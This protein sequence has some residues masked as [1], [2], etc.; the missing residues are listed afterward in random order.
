MT[1]S[2]LAL[3]PSSRWTLAALLLLAGVFI[4]AGLLLLT[5]APVAAQAAAAPGSPLHPVFP[6]LD[7]DGKPV[8][9]SAQPIS[10]LK[11][12]GSCHDTAFI[13]T[14]T[15]HGDGGR[16]VA[17]VLPPHD[18][19]STD[20][21]MNC[22]LCHVDQPNNPAR[23]AALAAGE[24]LWA[25]T[26]TL[27]DSGIVT[28]TDSGYGYNADAFAEDGSLKPEYVTLQDPRSDNCGA[29]HGLVHL[30]NQT[31]L[32]LTIGD[33][34]L[35]RTFTTGQ[36]ISPQRITNSAANLSGRS[37]LARPW[38]VHAERVLNCVDCH[39]SI[40]NPVY[41]QP[42]AAAQ[43][44]HL[45]FDPRRPDFGEYLQRP[46]HQFASGS[47]E[48]RSCETCHDAA[49]AHDWLPYLERHTAALACESCHVPQLYAPALAYRDSTVLHIDG[50]PVDGFRG[51]DGG[52][53]TTP[54]NPVTTL[55]TG[56]QPV[57][58]QQQDADGE[59][60]LSPYNL[61]TV[62]YWAVG[63]DPA[64]PV[65]LETV[66]AIYLNDSGSNFAPE[67]LAA[68]DTDS[69]GLL[70]DA[71]LVLD[72]AAKTELITSR[73]AAAG[74][75]DAHIVGEVIPYAIHHDVIGG[76][77]AIRDCQTCHADDSRIVMTMPLGDRLPGGSLPTLVS[78]GSVGWNGTLVSDSAGLVGFATRTQT[79][80]ASLYIFGHD[81]VAL[82]DTFGMLLVLGTA[83][84]VTVH[85]SLWVVASR[86]RKQQ[87]AAAGHAA[88][89]QHAPMQ[90]EYMYTLYER[91]W[92][93]LQTF[94]IF[95]LVF[96]GIVIH[97]P[98]QFSLFS[99]AW[100][101]D[102]HNIFAALLV[103]N[104][105]LA[106]FYHL[107]SGEIRQF[108][109]R[110]YGFFDNM[111]EQALYYLRGIF[112]GD[113]HP[114]EKR[115]SQKMNPIQQ[116]TYLLLLN[117]LLPLQILSGAVMWGAQQFP[118][119]S[120]LVGGLPVLA[121]LHT[122][123]AWLLVTF[124]IV[125]VYMTTTGH[126]PLANIQAMIMGYEEIEVGGAAAPGSPAQPASEGPAEG[127]AVTPA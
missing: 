69:D 11:T 46:S 20:V 96:T 54:T 18:L 19:P 55:I 65:P 106:L 78:D 105:A 56:Y 12:C 102:V 60:S 123:V 107:T 43:P 98:E 16:T 95:G 45:L 115:Q 17:G 52:I 29:C 84:G 104:A 21:E 71:E 51:I 97:R 42:A 82:V 94:V 34:Q 10:T 58:L 108:I 67:I 35:W 50:S 76:E 93:W 113:P 13:T 48:M 83:F 79:P 122:L 59:P 32:N 117:V 5:A 116:V 91:Q 118:A 120:D 41:M 85:A 66:Q 39:F 2:R 119:V 101:V 127:S 3:T 126:T 87:A 125:H 4:S 7:A 63:T 33:E 121:P 23:L 75:A 37:D 47:A 77:W 89:S 38:D 49:V 111:V 26:A 62:W 72:T 28:R 92:H 36:V 86:R 31:P 90:R 103:I 24:T 74:V 8:T 109:P 88:A 81:S 9:T 30:E 68:F 44:D 6:L 14:H 15:R 27:V 40:N 100:M 124:V 99:F 53:A 1:R 80:A 70:T 22:F 57:L 73:L 110:P 64:L 114:F 112:R 25:N 61:V